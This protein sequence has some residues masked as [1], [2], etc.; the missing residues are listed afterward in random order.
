M[1]RRSKLFFPRSFFP[2]Y[3]SYCV[4]WWTARAGTDPHL[5]GTFMPFTQLELHPLILK[6]VRAAGYSEPTPIQRRAI[7]VILEGRDLIGAAQTGTGKTAAFVLPILSQLIDGPHRLRA[8]V[9]TP[10]RELCAQV[11]AN[12]Q[13]YAKY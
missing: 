10:T 13:K 5:E 7:P 9:L 3:L 6:A 1:T 8:L 2:A 12:G 4:G 11:T